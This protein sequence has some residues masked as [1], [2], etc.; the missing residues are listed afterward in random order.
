MR[1]SH[2][3]I[4]RVGGQRVLVHHHDEDADLLQYSA[5]K[6]FGDS[7]RAT[8]QFYADALLGE[9]ESIPDRLG[10]HLGE[11]LDAD[12]W[13]HQVNASAAGPDTG[14]LRWNR[15]LSLWGWAHCPA[16]QQ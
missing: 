4:T 10:W 12:I 1:D 13:T 16:E 9:P 2:Q 11:I 3:L 14:T 8:P 5:P 7:T 15:H 6:N